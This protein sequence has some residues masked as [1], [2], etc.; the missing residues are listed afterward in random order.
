MND[1][2]GFTPHQRKGNWVIVTFG[3]CGTGLSSG[4]VC[5][6]SHA[7]AEACV[8]FCCKYQDM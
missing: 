5:L 3:E 7:H 8:I 1:M 2:V 4:T 6:L